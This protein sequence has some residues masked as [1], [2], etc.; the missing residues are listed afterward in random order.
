[1]RVYIISYD[2]KGLGKD[3]SQ[4][5]DAIRRLGDCQHPLESVWVVATDSYDQNSI[6]SELKPAMEQNDLL[7]IL[8]VKPEARQGWLAKSFWTW[9][10]EK[11]SA[12]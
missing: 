2:L 10:S 1:M 7:L 4:L 3:Y 5:Y 6:Y 11:E 8:E 12:I 9:M